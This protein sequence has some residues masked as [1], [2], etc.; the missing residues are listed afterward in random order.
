MTPV[1]SG[2]LVYEYS[3][4]GGAQQQKYGLVD[5]SNGKAFE[6]K[7]F[8]TVQTAFKNTPM[9]TGDGGY[10]TSGEASTCPPASR[11][12]LVSNDSLPAMPPKASQ[13]FKNGAGKGPG[14]EGA[15]SQEVGAESPGT[16]TAGSGEPTTTGQANAGSNGGSSSPSGAANGLHG[17][18]FSAAPYICGLVVLASTL[19]GATLL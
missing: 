2:G 15:G 12:W 3:V 10:K 17:P 13:Y 8:A 18:A 6:E 19:F 9:P 1:Y 4:E 5:L 11:T 7:D 14:F 16:A